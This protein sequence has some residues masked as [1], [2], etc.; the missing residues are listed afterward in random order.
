MTDRHELRDRSAI[1]A[2]IDVRRPDAERIQQAGAV[3]GHV[4][5]C[6]GRIDRLARPRLLEGPPDIRE[7]G[8]LE[9]GG[10]PAIAVVE[11]DRP[12]ARLAEPVDQRIRPGDELHPEPADHQDRVAAGRAPYLVFDLDPVRFRPRHD[13]VPPQLLDSSPAILSTFRSSTPRHAAN[14]TAMPWQIREDPE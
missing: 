7:P 4:L 6:V 14:C 5:D 9:T 3:V 1:G 11:Q 13:A 2:A 10:E 8:L 12:E